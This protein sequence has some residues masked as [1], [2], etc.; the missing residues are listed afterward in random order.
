MNKSSKLIIIAV[1]SIVFV[2][3]LII[4]G[5]LLLVRL[6]DSSLHDVS[7]HVFFLRRTSCLIWQVLKRKVLAVWSSTLR[8]LELFLVMTR[9]IKN[10]KTSLGYI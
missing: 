2:I 5:L 6:H 1:L 8:G 9:H 10:I 3:L 4:C 7:E